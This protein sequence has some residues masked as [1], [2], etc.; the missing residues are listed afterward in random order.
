MISSQQAILQAA[1]R[2]Q[3]QK[4][5]MHIA[6]YDPRRTEYPDGSYVLVEYP[7]SAI[8]KGPPN[9]L[10][11]YLKGPMKVINHRASI[12]KLSNLATG[13]EETYHLAHIRPFH[14]D[15][16]SINPI[17]IANRDEF[18]TP[19]ESIVSHQPVLQSYTKLKRSELFFTVRWKD[20]PESSDRILPYKELR[21]NPALHEYLAAKGMRSFIPSEHKRK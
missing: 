6:D 7:R 5:V 11:L 17:D 13:K 18:A 2:S 12:Y 21:N 16:Q 10:N 9:K 1:E 14:Y 3:T 19:V 4:D 8:K 20:L 15:E